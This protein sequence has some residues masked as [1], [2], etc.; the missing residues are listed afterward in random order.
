MEQDVFSAG[1][2]SSSVGLSQDIRNHSLFVEY[3]KLL[4]K[5][6]H[7]KKLIDDRHYMDAY[8]YTLEALSH[9]ARIC[10]LEAGHYPEVSIMRQIKP[11]NCGV[12]KLY[13][14]LTTSSESI[15]QRVELVLLACE[16]GIGSMLE[17]CSIPLM[18]ALRG[19][20]TCCS[21][22]ELQRISG[23][24]EVGDG[25]RLILDKLTKKSLVKVVFITNDYEL[26]ELE[27][28]YTV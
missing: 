8:R 27:I 12:Y 3:A 25:I 28:T 19:C 18:N 7:S 17:K 2:C 11:I 15:Q 13:E 6:A 14:E 9:W 23:L 1:L 4:S 10:V 5:C 22:E 16:F 24:R 21:I 20:S 26:N